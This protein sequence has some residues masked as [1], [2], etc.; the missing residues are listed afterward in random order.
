MQAN[1]AKSDVIA[2]VSER[3]MVCRLREAFGGALIIAQACSVLRTTIAEH[4]K[5][6]LVA[7]PLD[8]D[9]TAVAA[10]VT[11][12]LKRLTRWRCAVYFDPRRHTARE[13]LRLGNI[14]VTQM[15]VRDLDD[16][17]TTLRKLVD[18]AIRPTL[19]LRFQDVDLSLP[20][21]LTAVALLCFENEGRAEGAE[22][23]AARLSLSR[24]TLTNWARRGGF[25]G[26]ESFYSR[27]RVAYALGCAREYPRSLES[28]ALSLGYGSGA[29]LA[30]MVR[31]Y[32]G[33]SLRAATREM[34]YE[35]WCVRL[36]RWRT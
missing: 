32:T 26:I 28:L 4:P 27:C 30:G 7:E 1:H 9:G 10:T 29:H 16:A 25:S 20:D 12:C 6:F 23:L 17:P 14:G 34:D 24:R 13:I 15:I 22:E 18:S 19:A 11:S 8:A 35:A 5:A 36:L 31:R 21:V 3:V 33:L 2:C